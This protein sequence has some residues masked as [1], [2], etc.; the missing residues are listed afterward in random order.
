ME[1]KKTIGIDDVKVSDEKMADESKLENLSDEELDSVAGGCYDENND[2]RELEKNFT[3]DD[4]LKVIQ[5]FGT[6]TCSRCRKK[7]HTRFYDA[8]IEGVIYTLCE[9]CYSQNDNSF[10]SA[11]D[12]L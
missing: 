9:D 4:E 11:F 7:M 6:S 2:L 3:D 12:W 1:D 10:Y 8:E 5:Y